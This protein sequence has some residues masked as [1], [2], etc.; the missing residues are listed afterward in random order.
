MCQE[1]V[2]SNSNFLPEYRNIRNFHYVITSIAVSFIVGHYNMNH[3]RH[4]LPT[5]HILPRAGEGCNSKPPV[6]GRA[7]S[8]IDF[9]GRG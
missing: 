7:A 2:A 9:Q 3:N 1:I 8:K 4:P 6:I 5:T